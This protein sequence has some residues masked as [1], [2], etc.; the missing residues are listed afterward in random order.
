MNECLKQ[1]DR[2][3]A[4]AIAKHGQPKKYNSQRI[5]GFVQHHITP[6]YMGGSDDGSNIVYLSNQEHCEAHALFAKANPNDNQAYFAWW[7]MV[8][9][10]G[11]I[12]SSED[13]DIARNESIRRRLLLTEDQAK[14]ADYMYRKGLTGREIAEKFECH[15]QAVRNA[16]LF[17]CNT[18]F[19]GVGKR[20]A[21]LDEVE[22][23][24]AI[25]EYQDGK[26][27][28]QIGERFGCSASAVQ[29]VLEQ[30]GITRRKGG[31]NGMPHTDA[32]KVKIAAANSGKSFTD[33]TRR[34][35]SENSHMKGRLPW[36]NPSTTLNPKAMHVWRQL[37]HIYRLWLSLES[38]GAVK[39]HKAA[40]ADLGITCSIRPFHTAI[41][42]FKDKNRLGEII[43]AQQS[44]G[45]WS[46]SKYSNDSD[47]T[48]PLT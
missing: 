15:E 29:Y 1:Y 31:R 20:N 8:N 30:A 21:K 2:I 26:T 27:L 43:T 47:V 40:K 18:N 39:L 17:Y 38:C 28:R 37:E 35:M 3:I 10:D 25:A 46:K 32:T 42:I 4:N 13:Y 16:M 5:S 14:K 44:I 36:E 7:R 23:I 6:Q 33:K 12:V 34:L 11:V 41:A 19:K 45:W 48:A 24:I 22:S 9:V